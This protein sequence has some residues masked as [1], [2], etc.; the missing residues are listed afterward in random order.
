METIHDIYW[1]FI[2]VYH[3]YCYTCD[4]LQGK[5]LIASIISLKVSI[6]KGMVN[7]HNIIIFFST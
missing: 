1:L 7:L 4:Q 3:Q 5:C 2:N 6:Y